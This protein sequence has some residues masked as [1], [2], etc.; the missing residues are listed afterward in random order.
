MTDVYP[1][2]EATGRISSVFKQMCRVV[3][4]LTSAEKKSSST[5]YCRTYEFPTNF[6][7]NPNCFKHQQL[8][9]H[10]FNHLIHA[11]IINTIITQ[12]SEKYNTPFLKKNYS[13]E[14]ST[15]FDQ[16]NR[17]INNSDSV[18]FYQENS[19]HH[20]QK[21]CKLVKFLHHQDSFNTRINLS[22]QNFL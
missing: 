4:S 1:K 7:P 22:E 17:N 13:Y 12:I 19:N 20:F 15:E 6:R 9:T 18:Y 10:H 16:S 2:L 8:K 11:T 14:Y 21:S 5:T 3:Q